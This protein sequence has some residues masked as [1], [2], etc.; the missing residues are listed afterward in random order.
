MCTW[1]AAR[2]AVLFKNS[3]LFL[4]QQVL[5]SNSLSYHLGDTQ[6]HEI[7]L[8][9]MVSCYMRQVK[10]QI[11]QK[12]FLSAQLCVCVWRCSSMFPLLNKLCRACSIVILK[13]KLL[14]CILVF[15]LNSTSKWFFQ[16]RGANKWKSIGARSR[17]YIRCV[18]TS[19]PI[20][21][22]SSVVQWASLPKGHIILAWLKPISCAGIHLADTNNFLS[23]NNTVRGTPMW[24]LSATDGRCKNEHTTSTRVTWAWNSSHPWT[25][26]QV[27]DE[28][29]HWRHLI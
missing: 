24:T 10:V 29:W 6:L 23:T 9:Q 21:T 3:S 4:A 14:Y 28:F 27:G 5:W 20:S 26:Q 8:L 2:L 18:R 17:L 13:S 19:Q 12:D 22:I 25:L 11:F 7:T 15:K 1:C 16:I